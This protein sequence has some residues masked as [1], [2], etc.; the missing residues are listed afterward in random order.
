MYWTDDDRIC[1][2]CVHWL[3]EKGI[4]IPNPS[5][6]ARYYVPE[7]KDAPCAREGMGVDLCDAPGHGMTFMTADGDCGGYGDCWSPSLEFLRELREAEDA[8][9]SDRRPWHG[10][11]AVSL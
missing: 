3:E 10:Q 8:C 5:K 6:T 11:L 1:G 2:N 7:L 9:Q 4:M